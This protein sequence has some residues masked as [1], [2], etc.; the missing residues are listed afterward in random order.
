MT[1]SNDRLSA[2]L[3]LFYQKCTT[4]FWGFMIKA[5][6]HEP[7][8]KPYLIERKHDPFSNMVKGLFKNGFF[9]SETMGDIEALPARI[10][11]IKDAHGLRSAAI[12]ADNAREIILRDINE[13]ETTKEDKEKL[14]AVVEKLGKFLGPAAEGRVEK[15]RVTLRG[16]DSLRQTELL[17]QKAKERKERKELPVE[18]EGPMTGKEKRA[19]AR[20]VDLFGWAPPVT[21][22]TKS[23]RK[24]RSRSR[25]RPRSR[26]RSP[27]PK[28][29]VALKPR[30]RSKS[31]ERA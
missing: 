26:P 11:K 19:K 2:A 30:R 23:H 24:S 13:S 27:K 15:M 8:A 5:M 22:G 7:K 4:R 1:P 9:S 12:A 16:E 31:I 14:R 3:V 29:R 10:K 20:Y 18:E 25:S 17:K 6:P 28:A 21:S